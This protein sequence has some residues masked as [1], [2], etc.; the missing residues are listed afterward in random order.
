MIAED[1]SPASRRRRRP[2]G[3]LAGPLLAADPAL[4]RTGSSMPG[5]STCTARRL[6][7]LGQHGAAAG[8]G[9]TAVELTRTLSDG[10]PPA[11]PWPI[12][13]TELG[14][15]T[16]SGRTGLRQRR[17]FRRSTRSTRFVRAS[18]QWSSLRAAEASSTRLTIPSVET[19]Y[20]LPSS[21]RVGETGLG[22]HQELHR[23]PGMSI[24]ARRPNLEC[25]SASLGAVALGGL[26]P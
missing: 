1:R 14:W 25:G 11:P 16:G 7:P 10:Q 26:R 3:R 13:I 15:N 6:S 24:G 20:N 17:I 12:W 4:W 8:S 23:R 9:A 21:G 18:D 19:D 22:G 2:R 5:A